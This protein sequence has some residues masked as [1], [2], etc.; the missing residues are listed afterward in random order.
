MRAETIV[1]DAWKRVLRRSSVIEYGRFP[2]KRVFD[3]CYFR[4]KVSWFSLM[5][6]YS[7]IS[8]IVKTTVLAGQL[9]EKR[10]TR[11]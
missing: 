7:I 6:R 2:T 1:P 3:M 4:G 11:R 9:T 5:M 8:I 10:G